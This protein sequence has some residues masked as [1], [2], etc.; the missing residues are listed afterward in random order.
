MDLRTGDPVWLADEPDDLNFP[1]IR[2]NVSCDVAIIGAG[3]TG[4]LVAHQLL[5]AG[6]SV[7]VLDKRA[8]GRGST[9][10]ST[11]LLMY[12][13]DTS[14]ADLARL[15]GTATARRVYQLGNKAVRELSALTRTLRQPCGFSTRNSLYLATKP[16]DVEVL[17]S[18]AARYRPLH[19]KAKVLPHRILQQKFGVDR[20]AALASSG[21]GQVNAFQLTRAVFRHHRSNPRLRL[22]QKANVATLSEQADGCELR[23]SR[24]PR[25]R[26]RFV[27]VATGYE[28]GRFI[29][30]DLI[31]L[32]STYVIA[33]KPFPSGAL[34]PSECLMWE[35]S[36]P[37]FYLRTTP[38]HRI[39]FGGRDEP[40]ADAPRRDK[41][42]TTKKRQLEKQFAALFPA[43]AFKAECAWTGT[44]A[45]TRDGLPCIGP[46]VTGS[47]V[48]FA[49]GYG[50]NG[51]TFS[52]IAAR[53][54]RDVCL[55]KS[56]SDAAL[57]RFDRFGHKPTPSFR[58]WGARAS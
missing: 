38:D 19:L 58:V 5:E 8:I 39:I 51:I 29:Q 47:H 37:Y 11:G 25:V 9:A 32:H 28:A 43:L 14:L 26:A 34:W 30:S 2:K 42:L 3:I 17:K 44:F 15:H 13:T 41:M 6:L 50:G 7:V 49:L 46:A 22:F 12:Q 18:E 55:D 20:P 48:L 52:Q 53:L 57:F 40:F 36:R 16:A 54:L 35:T 24:G 23:L 21:S 27:I 56:N 1:S 33:S 4:A 31:R 10:A 45:E